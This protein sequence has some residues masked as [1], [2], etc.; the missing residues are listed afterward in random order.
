MEIDFHAKNQ[1][2][3]SKRLGKQ[4]RCD[5]AGSGT[6]SCQPHFTLVYTFPVKS[7]RPRR[8]PKAQTWSRPSI[9]T[10]DD[11]FHPEL[12]SHTCLARQ[13]PCKTKALS[14]QRLCKT[15]ALQDKGLVRQTPCKTKAL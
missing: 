11:T 3:I 9:Y 1:V 4:S 10:L 12:A 13:R 2:N 6:R 5:Y 8:E 14:R 7:R 15:K